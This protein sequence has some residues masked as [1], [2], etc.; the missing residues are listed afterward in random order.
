MIGTRPISTCANKDLVY[1]TLSYLGEFLFARKSLAFLKHTILLICFFFLLFSSASSVAVL[2]T[3]NSNIVLLDEFKGNFV[4]EVGIRVPVYKHHRGLILITASQKNADY[5][6]KLIS[7]EKVIRQV[8][9]DDYLA[10]DEIMLIKTND[11]QSCE[12]L[13]DGKGLIDQDSP[14]HIS[15][16]QIAA[17]ETA[18]IQG[19]KLVTDAGSSSSDQETPISANERDALLVQAI[20]HFEETSA[21]AFS[22]W[23]NLQRALLSF[24]LDKAD[25]APQLLSKVIDSSAK[26]QSSA[27]ATALYELAGFES[28]KTKKQALINKGISISRLLKDKTGIARG[29]NYAA[30]DLIYDSNHEKA[31]QYLLEA[32]RLNTESASWANQLQVLH[33]L[34]WVHRRTGK[35]GDALAFAIEQKLLAERFEEDS[36]ILWALYN[37]GRAYNGLGEVYLAEKIFDQALDSIK[38]QKNIHGVSINLNS[39]HAYLLQ[40]KTYRYLTYGDYQRAQ[41]FGEKLLEISK[42]LKLPNRIVSAEA[43]LAEIAHQRGLYDEAHI[44]YQHNLQYSIE[45]KKIPQQANVLI[46]LSQ[47]ELDRGDTIKAAEF[48]TQ[49]LDTL[50]KIDD[51]RIVRSRALVKSIQILCELGQYQRAVEVSIKARTIIEQH[52]TENDKI[53][54]LYLQSIALENTGKRDSAIKLLATARLELNTLLNQ[55]HSHNLRRIYLGLQKRIYEL[56]IKL[57]PK[58]TLRDRINAL[59]LAEEF[60]ART[61]L[62]RIY[63][64]SVDSGNFAGVLERKTLLNEISLAANEYQTAQNSES[65][66]I[67]LRS[68]DLIEKIST[69]E[70]KALKEK[71]DLLK[72]KNVYSIQDVFSFQ[73]ESEVY[74]EYFIGDKQG[75]V[76]IIESGNV[77]IAPIPGSNSLTALTQK[78]SEIYS[79]P[80]LARTGTSAWE[81]TKLLEKAGRT[82]LG[83]LEDYMAKNKN[84][85]LTSLVIVPDGSLY[86]FPFSAIAFGDSKKHLIESFSLSYAPSLAAKNLINEGDKKRFSVSPKEVALVQPKMY[87]RGLGSKLAALPNA[88]WEI[89]EINRTF[90]G[91]SKLLINQD[92]SVENLTKRAQG[93]LSIL[94]LATHGLINSNEPALSGLVMSGDDQSNILWTSAEISS[95]ELDVGLVVLSACETAE[96]QNIEGEGL[97]S[98]SRAFLESG[99][100]QVVGALWKIADKSTAALMTTFYA[101]LRNN[102]FDVN[103]A[104]RKAQLSIKSDKKQEWSDPYYWAGIQAMGG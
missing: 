39:L 30:V 61:L 65:L 45:N 97:M 10:L 33:N 75:W 5:V 25:D 89:S 31:F 12:I 63:S 73:K 92:A 51:D 99:A 8:D 49:S 64:N 19:L 60:R 1:P 57:A 40:E 23:A 7:D 26:T 15:L 66:D 101:N 96:G 37:H 90:G 85:I 16:F 2:N 24:E 62:E 82:L 55:F 81:Q 21:N 4:D 59:N 102:S 13:I 53:E 74:L 35:S 98:L 58:N 88:D 93:G 91:N 67:L 36:E 17:N 69:L 3:D 87:Q 29:L 68:R 18:L 80:P 46:D 78:V 76:F 52:G 54:F 32:Y 28:N 72:F 48:I 44:R 95:T 43:L 14:Y 11:C 22:N 70:S 56:S 71:E 27:H 9:F 77:D 79:L 103:E 38:S 83:P 100:K 47:L 41:D 94:H 20:D 84:K 34:S 104:L 6:L 42:R 50:K 86:G